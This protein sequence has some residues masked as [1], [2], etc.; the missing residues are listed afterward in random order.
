MARGSEAVVAVLVVSLRPVPYKDMYDPGA[1]GAGLPPA[2]PI[3]PFGEIVGTSRDVTSK[4][5]CC[6]AAWAP[7]SWVP[8]VDPHMASAPA[9]PLESVTLSAFLMAPPPKLT[10][11]VADALVTGTPN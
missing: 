7:N 6:P 10:L 4:S 11:K 2:A 1:T 5:T 9:M 8:V 3:A